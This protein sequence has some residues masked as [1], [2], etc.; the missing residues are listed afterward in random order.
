[1]T[2]DLV[3]TLADRTKPFT[4]TFDSSNFGLGTVLYQKVDGRLKVIAYASRGLSKTEQNYAAHKREFLAMKWAICDKFK[5]YLLGSK[6]TVITD[7]NPLTYVMKNATLD[8]TS[9]RWMAELSN[10]DI[11]IQY[12]KGSLLTDAD[13]LSR[14]PRPEPYLDDEF[15]ETQN[16]IQKFITRTQVDIDNNENMINNDNVNAMTQVHHHINAKEI[17]P[18]VEQCMAYPCL[19]SMNESESEGTTPDW[20]R[21]QR[22]DHNIKQVIVHKLRGQKLK[23]ENAEQRVY[24]REWNKLLIRQGILYRK[25][26]DSLQPDGFRLQLVVPKSHRQIAMSGI[27]DE[28]F[29]NHIDEAILQLRQRF[30]WPFMYRD[31]SL[32]IKNC[33]RCI[34]KG[35]SVRRHQWK[36]CKVR[37]H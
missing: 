17:I 6:L 32:K 7:N 35:Q 28:L 18:V 1:M 33:L 10:Y 19:L 30:F 24:S 26:S 2:S 27:H 14:I 23:T 15:I 11:D 8:A 4:L 13:G 22:R 37:A 5:D 25:V 12:R 29:H 34:K 36:L 21:L 9:H 20:S 16:K 31:L 3:L